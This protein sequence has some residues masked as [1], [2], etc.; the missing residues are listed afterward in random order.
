MLQI[1]KIVIL[2]IHTLQSYG[3]NVNQLF[4]LL[5]E[6]RDQY[7]EILMKQWVTVFRNIFEADNYHPMI[8]HNIKE[9]N[10]LLM[11]FPFY[12]VEAM[13]KNGLSKCLSSN[14]L[15]NGTSSQTST[16]TTTPIA[17]ITSAAITTDHTQN[18]NNRLDE[19]EKHQSSNLNQFSQAN[20]PVNKPVKFPF[21]QFVPKV[22]REVKMYIHACLEFS[23]DLNTS[24]TE[25]E[26]MV[27]TINESSSN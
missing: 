5:I 8:V 10:D 16:A 18:N 9:L 21:S 12:D 24:Q 25:I 4:N 19:I 20:T 27:R 3:Y 6:I 13:N 1:K 22:F 11:E 23:H 14:N 7:N 2:F 15:S 17:S 26:D